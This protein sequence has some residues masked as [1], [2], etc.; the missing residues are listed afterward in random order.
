M[1]YDCDYILISILLQESDIGDGIL[2]I[3]KHFFTCYVDVSY[4]KRRT[5][6]MRQKNV[7]KID[8][9]AKS[10]EMK[11]WSNYFMGAHISYRL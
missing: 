2:S 5:R 1:N 10:F 8:S 9:M 11:K 7:Q 4:E 3:I 6:G